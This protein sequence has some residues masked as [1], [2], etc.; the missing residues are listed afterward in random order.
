M[1]TCPYCKKGHPSA[2]VLGWQVHK[3][4]DRWIMCLVQDALVESTSSLAPESRPKLNLS[5]ER[6]TW[7][8][9]PQNSAAAS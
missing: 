1:R 3:F 9:H 2:E 5:S 8:S 7:R 4:S 6:A